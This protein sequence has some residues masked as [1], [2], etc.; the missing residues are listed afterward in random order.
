MLVLVPSRRQLEVGGDFRFNS[1][2]LLAAGQFLA[3]EQAHKPLDRHCRSARGS[4]VN[5]AS[6]SR[7]IQLQLGA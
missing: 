6:G 4:G 3:A 2:R 5:D 7:G 1:S